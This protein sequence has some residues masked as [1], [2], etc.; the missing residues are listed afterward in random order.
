MNGKCKHDLNPRTCSL[1]ISATETEA[2]PE[3]P[4]RE[5]VG[6]QIAVV[7]RLLDEGSRAKIIR[8]KVD[9]AITI[10]PVNELGSFD[11]LNTEFSEIVQQLWSVVCTLGYLFLPKSALTYRE[12][13]DEGPSRCYHCKTPLSIEVGVLGC[14][15]CRYYVCRCG[16]CLCGYTGWNYMK[17]LFSQQ[18]PLP[19]SREER[20]EY[21]RVARYLYLFG[22]QTH[23]DP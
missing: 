1:C 23:H 10:V 21:I 17:Q 8:I 16:R 18:P 11:R 4:L 3:N 2:L 12:Q 7:L 6:G 13:T 19:V 22:V 5:T 14:T 20:V 15:Q 9:P